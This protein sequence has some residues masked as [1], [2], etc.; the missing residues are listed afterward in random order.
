VAT[1]YKLI[2]MLFNCE[3]HLVISLV[4]RQAISQGVVSWA[5]CVDVGVASLEAVRVDA[6]P[7]GAECVEDAS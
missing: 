6:A 2:G 3:A 5:V 1:N 7:V 4:C